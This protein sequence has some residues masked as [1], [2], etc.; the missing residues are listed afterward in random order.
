MHFNEYTNV[1]SA[2]RTSDGV[3]SPTCDGY[4]PEINTTPRKNIAV[5]ALMHFKPTKYTNNEEN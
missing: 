2:L 3:K 1:F 4:V 5:C